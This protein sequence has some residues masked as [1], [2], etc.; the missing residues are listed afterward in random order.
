MSTPVTR[1]LRPLRLLLPFVAIGMALVLFLTVGFLAFSPNIGGGR[2]GGSAWCDTGISTATVGRGGGGATIETLAD[3]QRQNAS[4]IISVAKDMD[5]PPRAW[6]VALATAMQESTLRNID[7]GDR[8]SLGL[9]QQ[10]PSQGWG[11]PA[12]VTDPAY[13]SRIFYE[14]LLEVPGWESMPITVAAQT[15]QRSAFPD[16]Y[17]KWEPLAAALVEQVGDVAN[18]TGCEPG[19]TGALPPG[20]AGAAI[21]FALRELGKPYV[22]GATGPNAYDCSGLL[23]RAYEAAGMTIPRVSRDQ[24][25][26]GGHLP[27]RDV[28]PGDFLFYAHDT[29]DPSTIY[30]VTMF[31]GDDKMVEAPNKDHPVRVQPVPWDFEDLVPLATRPGTTPNPA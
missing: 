9:F 11:T 16:A 27:N 22:W 20:A 8:D 19:T 15:V 31:I 3:D 4:S 2:T 23:M 26:S 1:A 25:N 10:R 30:H 28:Q 6:L 12:Q 13:S 18:P 14:R 24:Y 29:S 17:A 7:Y 5:L 21:G